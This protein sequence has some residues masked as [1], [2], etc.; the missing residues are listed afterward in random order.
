M[1]RSDLGLSETHFI[2]YV[3]L[4]LCNKMAQL[5]VHCGLRLCMSPCSPAFHH[6][7][8]VRLTFHSK[9]WQTSSPSFKMST[10]ARDRYYESELQAQL[11]PTHL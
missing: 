7:E 10:L 5:S 2:A 3:G 9:M 11:I 6:V 4:V 1:N 8:S